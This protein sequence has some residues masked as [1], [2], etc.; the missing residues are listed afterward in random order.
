MGDAVLAQHREVHG[1]EELL[2]PD[3]DGVL[4]LPRKRREERVEP[5]GELLRPDAA[6]AGDGLELEHERPGVPGEMRLVRLVDRLQEHLGVEEVRV[7]LAGSGPAQRLGV[8]M[9]RELVPDLAHGRETGRKALRPSAQHFRR[10]G[11]VE[12]GVDSD[13]AKEG[14]RGV[15]LQHPRG[16]ALACVVPMVDDAAPAGIVPRRSAEAHA[17]RNPGGELLRRHCGTILNTRPS[18]IS[19]YSSPA[20]SSPKL[21]M[22][23]PGRRV[24]QSNS[25]T[26]APPFDPEAPHEAA[27]E[28]AI[29]IMPLQLRV[30]PCRGTHSPRSPS[31]R[32]R[33]RIPG[34]AGRG[35][36]DRSRRPWKQWRPSIRFQP[37][38]TASPGAL[39]GGRPVHL[40][41]LR[42][43]RRRRC[44]G[45]RW[46]DRRRT[47]RDSAAH[48]SRSPERAAGV[49]VKGLSA[50][51]E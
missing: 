10:G 39:G 5:V 30:W 33:G 29:E 46:P 25:S 24:G 44:R 48:S 45:R 37:K 49:W 15:L 13:G 22:V 11:R 19:T 34:Q 31:T 14:I 28:V 43:G 9:H 6:P 4:A 47:A 23:P 27:A 12:A 38:L 3:L 36:S 20:A 21:E 2:V 35:R 51:T 1:R 18:A 40:L 8:G 41:P 42:S 7:D 50:G 17:A 32:C 26:A 16:G